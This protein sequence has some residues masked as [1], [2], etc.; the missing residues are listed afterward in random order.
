M[1]EEFQKCA[2]KEKLEKHCL[3]SLIKDVDFFKQKAE[4]LIKSRHDQS[5]IF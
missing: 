3:N 5:G 1:F 4:T 2:A